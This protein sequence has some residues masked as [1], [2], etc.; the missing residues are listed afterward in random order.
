MNLQNLT[1]PRHFEE[2]I[3]TYDVFYDGFYQE[4]VR[5]S[6][7]N[8]KTYMEGFF[9]L[10]T[11]LSKSPDREDNIRC[12]IGVTSL[13]CFGFNDFDKLAKIFDR[14][15]P[16]LDTNYVRFTSWCAGKLVH[17]PGVDQSRY[18]VHLFERVLGWIRANGRRSRHLAAVYMIE[19][20]SGNAGGDAVVF[21]RLCS[22]R[23]GP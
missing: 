6:N 23:Y 16:Q 11:A 21:L 20:I 22:Q 9:K 17:H 13:H 10:L 12:S 1:I 14:V 8:L 18:V 2:I 7:D 5:M 15:I 4:M 19:A 3:Q